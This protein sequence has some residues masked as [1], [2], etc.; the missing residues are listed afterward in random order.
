[1]ERDHDA[2]I[3]RKIILKDQWCDQA[4]T[5]ESMNLKCILLTATKVIK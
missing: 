3:E 1:M 4:I 5:V 2:M